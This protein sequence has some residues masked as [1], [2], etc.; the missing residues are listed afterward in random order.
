MFTP[1]FKV[2]MTESP[3]KGLSWGGVKK[4]ISFAYCQ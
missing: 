1:G 4:V 2:L 3:K